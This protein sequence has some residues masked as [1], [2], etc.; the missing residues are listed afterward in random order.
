MSPPQKEDIAMR[1]W[2]SRWILATIALGSFVLVGS[3]CPPEEVE[4]KEQTG[5][6]IVME[7]PTPV[8]RHVVERDPD[9]PGAWKPLPVVR[10]QTA[11]PAGI[12]FGSATAW[13]LLPDTTLEV[14]GDNVDSVK[15]DDFTAIKVTGG[16]LV[17]ALPQ[18]YGGGV[19][20]FLY[21]VLAEDSTGRPLRDYVHGANPPPR[22][23]IGP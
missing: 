8:E 7:P 20:E 5:G 15:H 19:Q 21:S 14:F 6:P 17:L 18:G 3:A 23:I 16:E 12:D 10:V 13:I 1:Q 22:M 9:K 4:Q 11:K 2:Q